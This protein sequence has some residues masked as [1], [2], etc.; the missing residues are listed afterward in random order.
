MAVRVFTDKPEDLLSTIKGA[1][2]EGSVVGWK[3][4]EDGDFTVTAANIANH[5][6]MRP[7]VL[8]DRLLFNIIGKKGGTLSTRMYAVYHARLIEMLLNH[9]DDGFKS[10]AATAMPIS[11][12]LLP[13]VG[14]ET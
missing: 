13:S 9:F 6:W 12:D 10:A 1:V 8:S 3:V 4:D 7:K 11:G 14:T 2:S 5:A